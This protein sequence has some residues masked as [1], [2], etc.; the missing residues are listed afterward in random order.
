MSVQSVEEVA[1]L[2]GFQTQTGC[3]S[4]GGT[5]S[6]FSVNNVNDINNVHAAWWGEGLGWDVLPNYPETRSAQFGHLEPSST[7][8][9]QHFNRCNS[10]AWWGE[11]LGQ[12]VL[13]DLSWRN[14]EQLQ[15]HVSS[16]M[17]WLVSLSADTF[18]PLCSSL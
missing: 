1:L 4:A 17:Q 3:S 9:P 8:T 7:F 12:D 14:Q 18:K 11:G 2:V 10:A 6:C 15:P 5:V 16:S 13:P